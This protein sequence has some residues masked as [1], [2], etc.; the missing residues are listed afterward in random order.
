MAVLAG[1][2]VGRV[3]AA[4]IAIAQ[5]V[6]RNDMRFVFQRYRV[7]DMALDAFRDIGLVRVRHISVRRS[8][9]AA[10]RLE[11]GGLFGQLIKGTVAGEALLRHRLPFC[12]RC[13]FGIINRKGGR[14]QAD[15]SGQKDKGEHEKSLTLSSKHDPGLSIS[16]FYSSRDYESPSFS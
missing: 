14:Q 11:I 12:F 15:R 3:M 16:I 1:L 8:C 5:V 2:K 13:C 10:G 7:W 4:L 9:L 6:S